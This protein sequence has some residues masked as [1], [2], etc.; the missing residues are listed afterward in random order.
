MKTVNPSLSDEEL[1]ELV[2]KNDEQAFAL[3]IDRYESRLLR[4]GRKFL[5]DRGDIEDMVQ[6]VFVKAYQNIKSFDSA[7][8]FSPWIYRI[9]H[10][11]FVNALRDKSKNPTVSLDLDLL[12]SHPVDE[13][14]IEAEKNEETR[15]YIDRGLRQLP[16]AYREVLTLFYF[17]EL[18]Y[19]AIADVL[20]I[21]VG[22]VGVRLRRAREVLR[23]YFDANRGNSL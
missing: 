2:K 14:Y 13:T 16:P 10:N 5:S 8:K 21:P 3:L 15:T 9:A 17:E 19:Q 1:S 23:K 18:D 20:H 22:T 12:V 6:N 11:V 7:R 4:Y